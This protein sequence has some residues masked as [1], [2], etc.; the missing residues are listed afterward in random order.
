MEASFNFTAV[1]NISV[2]N[3]I[4]YIQAMTMNA[5]NINESLEAK[6]QEA[7]NEYIT[8][9]RTYESRVTAA[10]NEYKGQIEQLVGQLTSVT[11]GNPQ[12]TVPTVPNIPD[13]P[14][15]LSRIDNPVDIVFSQEIRLRDKR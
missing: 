10:Y 1:I 4:N 13:V 5:R 14:T 7:A 9:M 11:V 6:L 3:N 15:V 2:N 12:N 8:A